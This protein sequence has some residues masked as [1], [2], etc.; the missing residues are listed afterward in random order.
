MG[1][2]RKKEIKPVVEPPLLDD[3]PRVIK[4]AKIKQTKCTLCLTVY[5]AKRKHIEPLPD[6]A[7]IGRIILSAKCPIC[8]LHNELEFE[9]DETDD[10][11]L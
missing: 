9:E 1:I 5:Q 2:F 7:Y 4:L 3:V 11:V 6:S 8:G 10:Q